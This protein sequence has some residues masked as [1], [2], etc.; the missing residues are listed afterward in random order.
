MTV[1]PAQVTERVA[2]VRK[3]ME[4]QDLHA[5]LIR[6]TDRY[7]NEYVPT[8]ESTRVWLTGFTGSTGDALLTRDRGWVAVDGRYYLQADAETE[9]TPFAVERV[10]LGTSI[11]SAI[12]DLTRS[13]AGNGVR[14]V[15]Y[16]PDRYSVK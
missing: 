2:Q 12:T 14:R 15:G 11:S 6:G 4:Q 9:G 16:E 8:A 13:L 1:T 10:P 3:L 7:L 5:I